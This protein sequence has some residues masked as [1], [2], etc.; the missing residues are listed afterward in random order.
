MKIKVTHWVVVPMVSLAAAGWVQAASTIQF[1]STSYTA[2]ESDGAVTLTVQ[3]TGDTNTVVSVDYATADGTATNGLK[4]TAVSGTLAFAAGQTNQAIVVPILSEGLVEGV[5]SFR[6]VLTN[7]VGG[8]VLGTRTSATVSIRDNDI[9]LQFQFA[10]YS[11]A[12]D[13]G[14]V[15]I[16]VVREDD[17]DLPVTVDFATADLSATNG[18]DYTGTT[19]TLTLTSQERLKFVSV[20]ILNDSIKE[21]LNK[22][23]RVNLSN[24]V[25]ANLAS[26]KTAT[27]T[28][29]DNDQGFAFATNNYWVVEDAGV[30]LVGVLRGTD[31]TNS[32]VTVDLTTSDLTATNGKHYVGLSNTLSFLPGETR[33]VVPVPIL[34]D[35]IKQSTRAF[36]AVLSNPSGG[37]ELG[38]GLTSTV[39]ILDNDPGVGF[40]RMVYT[41][42]WG[43]AACS[44]TVLR[45][46]DGALGPF[47]VDYATS[48]GTA[49]A[50]QDYQAVSGT[51]TFGA[52][53]TVKS[54][55]I[56]ILQPRA[57]GS[58][59]NPKS[60]KVA[61]SNPTGGMILGNGGGSWTTASVSIAGAY[62]ILAPPFDTAL[63]ARCDWGVNLL[64]WAGGGQLQRADKP[65]G[66]WQTIATA[67]S[68]YTVQSPVSAAFYRVTRPRPVSLYVPSCYNGE[69]NLPL[70]ILLHGYTSGGAQQEAYMQLQPLAETR[71]FLYCYPD[72]AADRWG[73][74]FW[75]ATDACCDYGSTSIDDAGYV[76]AIIE[77][78]EKRFAVDCK[79]VY[80]IGHSNGGYMA[81]R[82]ACQSADLIAGIASLAGMTFLEPGRCAPSGPVN[83]LH[84]H[85]TVDEYE[86]YVGGANANPTF[87][88]NLPPYPGVLQTVRVWAGYNGTRDPVT[89]SAPSMDLD[90]NVPGLDT[91]VTRYTSFPSGGAVELWSIVGGTHI[92]TLYSGSSSSEFGP[93]VVDW[94]L[95]HPKP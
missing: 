1:S 27:I 75:N 67:K 68:P 95:A 25:G 90:L 80:L 18:V 89:D 46:N 3:R 81:Y 17:G 16:G 6:V 64:T 85:G 84:I 2:G 13:A 55:A 83:I 31:A 23:I 52:N 57:A 65:A 94:L 4:Y 45:G 26:Q 38:S 62:A 78:I 79:R 77:E 5:K 19:N 30:A 9:G 50:G 72:S 41:N 63:S 87:P 11:I 24:P 7:A 44:L 48:N 86:F 88:S 91:V 42:A 76:R 71:G 59:S 36:M 66:P 60:F 93:R 47:T 10:T 28:I 14:A 22:T 12:E 74:Q 70:V 49:V 21:T 15:R 92:P 82:M 33:Q 73:Y 20:P 29:V 53:E 56:P 8:S 43:E 39:H 61:L 58:A 32:A 51:L 40:D 35:G 69:T 54:L 37:A 34:N